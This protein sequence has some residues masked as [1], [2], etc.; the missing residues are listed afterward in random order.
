V[1]GSA[2]ALTDTIITWIRALAAIVIIV[3]CVSA[4]RGG[5]ALA[6]LGVFIA[7]AAAISAREIAALIQ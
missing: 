6:A 5:G 4:L 3:C 1:A 2:S 7:L